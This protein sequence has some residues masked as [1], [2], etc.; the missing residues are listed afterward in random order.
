MRAPTAAGTEPGIRIVGVSHGSQTG[1]HRPEAVSHT[2]LRQAH[3]VAAQQLFV[4]YPALPGN[5]PAPPEKRKVGGS[6]P[7]LTTSPD[8]TPLGRPPRR[9]AG[10]ERYRQVRDAL[11]AA[12][13]HATSERRAGLRIEAAK[14]ARISP[15]YLD[16]T[17]SFS[18]SVSVFQWRGGRPGRAA[19]DLGTLDRVIADQGRYCQCHG[20]GRMPNSLPSCQDS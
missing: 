7:P 1:S 17:V 2:A 9:E 5:R 14:R 10:A 6:T 20:S 3:N 18:K 15:L 13:P 16:L 8:G 4:L 11:L 12:E 19:V